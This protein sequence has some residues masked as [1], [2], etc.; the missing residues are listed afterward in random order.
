MIAVISIFSFVYLAIGIIYFGSRKQHY[1]HVSDTISELAETGSND[2]KLVSYA[3][4][5]PVG[6]LLFIVGFATQNE[7]LKGLS[8][9]LGTGYVVTAFFPC[10][11][12]S[13]LMGSSKQTVHNI[14]GV[15]QYAGGMFFLWQAAK[16]NMQ[17]FFGTYKTIVVLVLFGV[18]I[19]P[20]PKNPVR[21]LVQ[22]VTE[23]LLFASIIHLSLVQ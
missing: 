4:F 21:G 1:N 20:F 12:G 2:E 14:A 17:F 23:L 7:I 22:R 15:I 13:P 5:L 9:C 6:I 10:D 11:A 16:R 3:L 19:I 18:L 8:F